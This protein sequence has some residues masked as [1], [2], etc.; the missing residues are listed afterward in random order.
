MIKKKMYH[1]VN[2]VHMLFDKE[3]CFYQTTFYEAR[4]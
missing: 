4:K 1:P 3:V 2:F